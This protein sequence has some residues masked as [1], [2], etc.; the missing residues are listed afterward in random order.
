VREPVQATYNERLQGRLAETIW[1][2]GGCRSWHLD[3]NGR[4]SVMWPDFTF[5][6]RGLTRHLDPGDFEI[7]PSVATA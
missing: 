6:Y 3:A 4:D 1:D 2:T 5:R 7:E